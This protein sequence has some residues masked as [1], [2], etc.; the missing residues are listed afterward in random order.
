M[1]AKFKTFRFFSKI[2]NQERT[3]MHL[4]CMENISYAVSALIMVVWQSENSCS[5]FQSGGLNHQEIW[6]IKC[7]RGKRK[8]LATALVSLNHG[9]V[10]TI[11]HIYFH[12]VIITQVHRCGLPKNSFH[13]FSLNISLF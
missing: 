8:P 5:N 13:C 2:T 11:R 3:L 9:T 1:F 12:N 7:T 4:S 10:A 6:L